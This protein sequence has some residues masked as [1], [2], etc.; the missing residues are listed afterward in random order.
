MSVD[1]RLQSVQ[2]L[3]LSLLTQEH[4]AIYV[5]SGNSDGRSVNLCLISL[6]AFWRSEGTKTS[7]IKF[8]LVDRKQPL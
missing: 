3:F 2:S 6:F 7:S 5:S 4:K 1:G 8:A